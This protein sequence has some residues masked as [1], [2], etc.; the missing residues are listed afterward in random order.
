MGGEGAAASAPRLFSEALSTSTS[1]SGASAEVSAS[2]AAVTG[3]AAIGA[4]S[5]SSTMRKDEVQYAQES[6]CDDA[7]GKT[8]CLLVSLDTAIS[9]VQPGCNEEASRKMAEAEA[10][11]EAEAGGL[12]DEEVASDADAESPEGAPRPMAAPR[13]ARSAAGAPVC[14]SHVDASP[15]RSRSWPR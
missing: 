11:A 13:R 1:A 14:R 3:P 9:G 12:E 15:R 7:H 8:R 6:A 10:E 4:A 2:P 5:P